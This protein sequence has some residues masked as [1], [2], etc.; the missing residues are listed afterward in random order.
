[1][2]ISG[3]S[4]YL[5]LLLFSLLTLSC[6]KG[7]GS[8]VPEQGSLPE[9]P[10]LTVITE[11]SSI[12][13]GEPVSLVVDIPKGYSDLSWNFV[14][15]SGEVFLSQSDS[16]YY[17]RLD[18]KGENSI[19]FAATSREGN[20]DLTTDLN[21][22]CAV[23]YSL[24][25]DI[26]S[27]SSDGFDSFA[28]RCFAVL[29]SQEKDETEYFSYLKFDIDTLLLPQAK[30]V[31]YYALWGGLPSSHQLLFPLKENT[32]NAKLSVQSF[33]KAIKKITLINLSD[34][35]I[36][37]EKLNSSIKKD[38]VNFETIFGHSSLNPESIFLDRAITT[39]ST[40]TFTTGEESCFDLL[41]PEGVGYSTSDVRIIS[42]TNC[43][44]RVLSPSSL[45][46]T[47]QEDGLIAFDVQCGNAVH[48]FSFFSL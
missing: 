21:L 35:Y 40:P 18:E 14:K 20:D 31:Y 26:E 29:D 5:S 42:L 43:T 32:G 25:L 7:K 9:I 10:T 39:V 44:A 41:I 8:Y 36:I 13:K 34:D 22:T 30:D 4:P 33:V 48:Q 24:D 37:C 47:P 12:K 28:V 38:K 23:P 11:S 1:M 46:V 17:C 45:A 16:T 6:S 19:H 2:K 15:G 27:V 3:K